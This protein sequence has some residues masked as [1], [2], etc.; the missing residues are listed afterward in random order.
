MRKLGEERA[1]SVLANSGGVRSR[2]RLGD[3]DP[4]RDLLLIGVAGGGITP[5]CLRGGGGT[6]IGM[7]CC[8]G[9][10]MDMVAFMLLDCCKILASCGGV[11][12]R[13]R[14]G[15]SGIPTSSAVFVEVFCC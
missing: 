14:L 15:K 3:R 2:S 8:G 4:P 5:G 11:R 6:T 7:C 12:S 10:S 1:R 13:S 9:T